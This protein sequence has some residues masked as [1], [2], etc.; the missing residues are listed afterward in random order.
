MAGVDEPVLGKA[1][2][3][4]KEDEG[5]SIGTKIRTLVNQAMYGVLATQI[6][7][8][9]YSSMVSLAFS[10]DLKMGVFATP[11]TTRKYRILTQEDRIS[12][13]VDNREK[14]PENIMKIEAVT[15]TGRANRITKGQEYKDLTELLEN[16][17]PY[18]ADFISAETCALFCIEPLRFFYSRRFHEVYEWSQ[19]KKTP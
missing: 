19:T 6:Q 13:L 11:E 5:D 15:I 17:H 7:G 2:N 14:H 18:M 9:P 16:K 1:F 12:V 8:Q 3:K 4:Q 10:E